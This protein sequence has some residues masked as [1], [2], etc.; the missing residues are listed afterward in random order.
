LAGDA[1]LALV[2]AG[3]GVAVT[4]RAG[5]W[6]ATARI[7]DLPGYLL[8]AGAAL[9]LAVRRLWPVATLALTT[10]AVTGYL[11][12]GYPYGPIILALLVA[13]YTV[14]ARLPARP[15]TVAGAAV[16]GALLLHALVRAVGPVGTAAWTGLVPASA[17]VVVPFAVGRVVRV[18]RESRARTRAEEIERHGYE[19]RLRVA[20]EVHDIVGHGLAAIHLQAEIALHVLPKRPAQAETA[21]A[22]IS[23]TSKEALDELRAT[24]AVV[25]DVA[26]AL[27]RGLALG[28]D[29]QGGVGRGLALG[30]DQQGGV[31]RGLALGPDQQ[32]GVGRG[33]ALGP[34]QQGGDLRGL[35]L[36]PDQQDGGFRGLALGPDQQGGG[37]PPPPGL[38]R[39]D[40]LVARMSGTGVPVTVLVEGTARALPPGVDLAAYRIV[41]EALTNVLRH[42]D[43]ATATVRLAY[44][45]AGL[46]VE[47]T[48]DGRGGTDS[49][50]GRSAGGSG[51]AGMRE[52]VRGLG[53]MFEAGPRVGGGFR[54]FARLPTPPAST[55]NGAGVA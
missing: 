47:V 42:A 55:A 25:R 48:D 29:Q 21:L 8:V 1:L 37:C 31:G 30:P 36:G 53:G 44:A 49:G 32:G 20:R 26:G 9:P 19:E 38:G 7:P 51:L 15:A 24:L 35:A 50:A 52:R 12:G 6:P 11:L 17:W 45:A 16:L 22:A 41:Q 4:S 18:G 39:L 28:P 46:T 43:S 27:D 10:A 13:V 34:D 3:F 5:T 2:L 54:V 14:A 40:E 23:R 33:L